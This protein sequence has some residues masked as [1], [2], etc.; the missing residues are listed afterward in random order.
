MASRVAVEEAA[1]GSGWH[2]LL[3]QHLVRQTVERGLSRNSLEAYARDLND[4]H[5]FCGTLRIAPDQLDNR[6]VTSYLEN[7]AV[8]EF[9]VASQRRRLA[10]VRG[11]IRD[12]L[13]RGV[14]ESEPGRDIKL[15]P[16]SRPLPRTLSAKDIEL[17]LNTIDVSTL[18]GLRDRA[19]LEV[20]YGCGLRVSELVGLRLNQIELAAKIVIVFGK[21]GKERVVPLG[22]PALRAMAAYLAARHRQALP[23]T[24]GRRSRGVANPAMRPNSAAFITRLGRPMTRQGFFKALKGWASCD[25]RLAWISPH[26]LRHCFATHLLEGG[27]DLRAVQEMLGH[28]DISTTQLYTHLSR[29]H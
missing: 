28:S 22:G 8:R 4:F 14:L 24:S 21:G 12:L 25:E 7:L 20:A 5:R 2:Y 15:R 10:A 18:R 1:G 29:T 27:A 3:D 11:F 16:H 26:T 13:E 17:L 23:Q 19:M 9:A 6:V